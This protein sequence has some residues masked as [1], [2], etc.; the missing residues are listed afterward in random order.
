M[1]DVS[2]QQWAKKG[3][4]DSF[5]MLVIDFCHHVCLIFNLSFGQQ[6]A[7]SP[8]KKICHQHWVTHESPLYLPIR[9]PN[10]YLNI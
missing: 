3:V 9:D 8:I 7:I 2:C 10:P 6:N 4:G 1:N 5:L